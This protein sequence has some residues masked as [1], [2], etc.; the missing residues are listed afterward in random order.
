MKRFILVLMAIVVMSLLLTGCSDIDKA[1]KSISG[2]IAPGAAT[3]EPAPTPKPP[4][5]SPEPERSIDEVTPP[6]VTSIQKAIHEN[7]TRPP[8]IKIDVYVTL[9]RTEGCGNRYWYVTLMAGNENFGTKEIYWN[10][11]LHRD[12]SKLGYTS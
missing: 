12:F 3:P 4:S 1:R 9:E 5:P 7:L 11:D 10:K 8:W 6:K 2:W